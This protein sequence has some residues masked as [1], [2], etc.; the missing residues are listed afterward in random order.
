VTKKQIAV[1]G[2]L[3]AVEAYKKA[4]ATKT[5]IVAASLRVHQAKANVPK[6]YH[7][8]IGRAFKES[9]AKP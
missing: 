7:L 2:F 4:L 8:L 6:K 5:G 1:Q 9:K 3:G